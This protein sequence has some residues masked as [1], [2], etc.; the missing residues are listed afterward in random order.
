MT[1]NN[2]V[3][4]KHVSHLQKFDARKKG[5]IKCYGLK[6][7]PKN[8]KCASHS[9]N[10]PS[11]TLI[12][13]CS[14][15]DVLAC[16]NWN[17]HIKQCPRTAGGSVALWVSVHVHDARGLWVGWDWQ[18]LFVTQLQ[19]TKTWGVIASVATTAIGKPV[20]KML[21]LFLIIWLPE[22]LY[23]KRPWLLLYINY[24]LLASFKCHICV[25]V[26]HWD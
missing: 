25:H 14:H 1:I 20:L 15:T 23:N 17:T 3:T 4:S 24:I 11:H 13:S 19:R 16:H 6:I 21:K 9:L 2:V 8:S 26:N 5:I 12:L 7:W 22:L 10:H 18:L